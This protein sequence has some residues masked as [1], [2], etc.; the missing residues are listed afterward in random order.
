MILE[1]FGVVAGAFVFDSRHL[2]FFEYGDRLA[3]AIEGRVVFG[4]L[5]D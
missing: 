4:R 2:V 3:L 1:L 5:H